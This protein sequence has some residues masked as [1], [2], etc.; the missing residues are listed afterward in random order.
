MKK[1]GNSSGILHCAKDL[2][3]KNFKFNLMKKHN[4]LTVSVINGI[5]TY[6]WRKLVM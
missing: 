6:V 1:N 3:N 2:L 4:E 5:G